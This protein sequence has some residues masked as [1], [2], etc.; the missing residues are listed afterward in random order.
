MPIRVNLPKPTAVLPIRKLN[1]SPTIATAVATRGRLMIKLS[2]ARAIII[3]IK[4]FKNLT[5][6]QQYFIENKHLTKTNQRIV[7]FLFVIILSKY[8]LYHFG[9][10]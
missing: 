3:I 1:A 9:K 10:A 8:I 2:N 7:F 6:F 4:I 5:I